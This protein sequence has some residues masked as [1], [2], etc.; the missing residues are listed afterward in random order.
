M[1]STANAPL[2]SSQRLSAARRQADELRRLVEASPS[3]RGAG[4]LDYA[5]ATVRALLKLSGNR[6]PGA[7]LAP[8]CSAKA[9]PRYL[10]AIIADGLTANQIADAPA[11]TGTLASAGRNGNAEVFEVLWNLGCRLDPRRLDEVC[12]Q[13]LRGFNKPM[14]FTL[15]RCG[16]PFRKSGYVF[17]RDGS[18][19]AAEQRRAALY[20][21]ATFY[22]E[23][24]RPEGARPRSPSPALPR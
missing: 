18:T 16:Y 12:E 8:L 7:M 15:A 22:Q 11:S 10:K 5:C 24:L 21:E 23:G 4:E 1:A 3:G 9:S 19:P 14:L 17:Q 13:A 6:V 20:A 2:P